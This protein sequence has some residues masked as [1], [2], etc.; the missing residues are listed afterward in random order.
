MRFYV[1]SRKLK[2]F[3]C[4]L[5]I[6]SA[7]VQEG[8]RRERPPDSR[9]LLRSQEGQTWLSPAEDGRSGLHVE[10]LSRPGRAARGAARRILIGAPDGACRACGRVRVRRCACGVA[11]IAVRDCAGAVE[12]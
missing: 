9:P 4:G 11:P 12:I 10:D 1:D 5:E 3:R 7:L 2:R 8:A 6:L